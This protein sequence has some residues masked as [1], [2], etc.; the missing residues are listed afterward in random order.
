MEPRTPSHSIQRNEIKLG[1][2]DFTRKKYIIFFNASS[3]FIRFSLCYFFFVL[4]R[5][6]ERG[7]TAAN[8]FP[9]PD[10]GFTMKNVGDTFPLNVQV[11]LHSGEGGDRESR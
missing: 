7:F 5:N 1:E 8:Q 3:H 11:S 4:E 10:L 6:R 2:R 9:L